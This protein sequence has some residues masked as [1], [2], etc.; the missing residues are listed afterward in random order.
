[1][2]E[3]TVK[4][5]RLPEL[6]LPEI[7]RDEIVRTLSGIH[8]PEIDL[9]KAER[10]P[11]LGG[12]DLKAMPWRRQGLSGI[13]AGRLVA[14]VITAARIVRPATPRSSW[15]PFRR[16]RSSAL[17]RSRESVVAVIRPAP[18]RSR[19]GLVVVLIALAAAA[20]WMVFRSPQVRSRIDRAAQRVRAR[21]DEMRSRPMND[22]DLET[23]E[24]VSVT[25]TEDAPVAGMETV[26]AQAETEI[27]EQATNPA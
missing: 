18:R 3:F 7:K 20:G 6:H 2:P 16:S 17:R 26:T 9:T 14:A 21:V 24:P 8:V 11:K 4:E 1:M 19:R 27:T 10:R 13:D 5:V 12:F 23:G 15:F 25:A 22:I